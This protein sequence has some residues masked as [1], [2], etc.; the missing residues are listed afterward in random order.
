MAFRGIQSTNIISSEVGFTDPLLILNKDGAIPTDVG[1][2]GKIGATSYA[3]LVKDS[4]TDGFLLINSINLASTSVNSVD[5]TDL[6]LVPGD[7]TAGAITATSFTGDG[8][9]LTGITDTD[10]TYTSS[11]FTHNDLTG[12]VANEHIDWTSA[13][14]GTIHASNYT[15]TDTT[16]SVGDGGLTEKNF[17]TT[18]KNKLDT[19]EYSA[20]ATD[21][22]NVTSSGALMTTGGTLTGG[23]TVTGTVGATAFTGDGSALT[24]I[25]STIANL[26]D[27]DLTGLADNDIL[28]WNNAGG[29]W[30]TASNSTAGAT[31][32]AILPVAQARIGSNSAGTGAGCSFG[33]YNSSNGEIAVTFNTTQSDANYTIITDSEGYDQ[34]DIAT[35]T[36]TTTGFIIQSR[37][38]SG[39]NVSPSV[40]AIGF[41]VYSS[42]PTQSITSDTAT[43]WTQASAGTIHASNYT[44]TDTTY[45]AGTGL[46]LTG[47][48][49]SMTDPI[50]SSV[51]DTDVDSEGGGNQTIVVTGSNFTAG[52][53]IAFVGSSAS[54]DAA[55]TTYN[56]ATQVTAVSP[57]SSFLN[58]QEPYAVK[59][60]SISGRTGQSSGVIYV[61]NAPTWSTTAG[62]VADVIESAAITNVQLTA[63]DPEGDA[64]T[65][66][67]TT[68]N[69]SGAG[70]SLSSAGVISGTTSAVGS[71][72]TTS[73]DVRATAGSK[74]T[75][76]TFN[77]ITRNLTTSALLWDATSVGNLDFSESTNGPG[78][79][80]QAGNAISVTTAVTMSNIDGA[81]G[82]LANIN[83]K[84]DSTRM[85]T[86]YNI[87]NMKNI[88][89][90]LWSTSIHG[91]TGSN[92][93]GW[94]GIYQGSGEAKMWTTYDA[95]ANP[96]F[97]FRRLTGE[98]T[99]RSGS[100]V[101]TIYGTNNISAVNDGATF[102]N[103][104][105]TSLFTVT[106]HTAQTFDTGY[107]TGDFYRYYVFHLTGSGG[108]D[109]GLDACK[110][111]G[112]Y[113]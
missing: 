28:K 60:T 49:F 93:S 86:H 98:W 38:S 52:G 104:N 7:L 94:W 59:F 83:L 105:L 109:W 107:W 61:D 106:N 21:T 97:K 55:T 36:K 78:L 69:L 50:V 15:D 51:D 42:S 5:A 73:F 64:V 20:D 22:A 47:T 37:D 30:V 70:L 111:Y 31:A 82:T 44:D 101:F 48:T 54:F 88:G 100:M 9:A 74:T 2:L 26:T 95:G 66:S 80:D 103:T 75:D 8:S 58:A 76:R 90:T 4:A 46:T 11:D 91:H 84:A 108:Y 12:V 89:N 32:S 35:Y 63:T 57:K 112:D 92:N 10:T 14:A 25:A 71:H 41:I 13:S 40:F 33:A 39:S 67:E 45:T 85:Y 96:T 99:W 53:V 81:S 18:L 65:Y 62:N 87:P 23:I 113:Y 19:I 29:E 24:G 79:V 34:C 110:W 68:S 3:G 56:S 43:D 102:S 77:V 16:Y 27:V 1:F 6:S 17:T 72:T